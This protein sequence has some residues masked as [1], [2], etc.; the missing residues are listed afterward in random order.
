MLGLL[1]VEAEHQALGHKALVQPVWAA[2]WT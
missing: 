2:T 1:L